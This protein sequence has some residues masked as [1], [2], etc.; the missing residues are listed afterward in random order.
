[1]T[2]LCDPECRETVAL[3]ALL[4]DLLGRRVLE[5]GCGDGRLTRRY[6]HRAGPVLA[7]DPDAACIAAMDAD[8][9]G[10]NVT[11]H[12]AAL[13]DDDLDLPPRSFD[14]IIFSWSL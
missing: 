12:T 1:M 11:G 13:L 7:I 5:V 9:P 3:D 2:I 6:A 4:P 10:P 14:A 8:R